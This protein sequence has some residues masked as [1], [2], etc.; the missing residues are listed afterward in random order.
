[1]NIYKSLTTPEQQKI[2]DAR[3]AILSSDE[4]LLPIKVTS[5]YRQK[6][7]D[8]ISILGHTEGPLHRAVFPSHERITL[9]AP[10][11]VADFVH[12]RDNMEKLADGTIIRKYHERM[13][14]LP[15][16]ECLS[17][18]QYCFRQDVLSEQ[19]QE[20][21]LLLR[22]RLD[23]L[24]EYLTEHPE[25]QEVILSG[26]DPIM[27]PFRKL[28]EVFDNIM[29]VGSVQ[30][31]RLHTRGLIFNPRV[32]TDDKISLLGEHR[33]RV[34]NHSIH[35][36]ELCDEVKRRIDQLHKHNIRLYNQFP[37]LRKIND[38]V[39]VLVRHLRLL[40][41]QGIRNLSIFIPDAIH[42]SSAFRMSINRLFS[43]IDEF[44]KSTPSWVNSTRFVLDTPYGKVRREDMT[45]Y[46]ET[47]GEAV[48]E[49]NGHKITYPGLPEHMDEPGNLST[50]LWKDSN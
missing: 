10:G 30:A 27:L 34:V 23:G 4:R 18:C 12:D 41:E 43:I 5:F 15:T 16:S 42:Y 37:I 35:P 28:K 49:R 47:T 3:F 50:L 2:L 14:F 38:H 36:Y 1:M 9:K 40:D 45:S 32:F 48:F 7:A 19:R 6:V 11:E 39:E 17:N 44:N 21:S 33:I 29:G 20:E 13:L 8:E 46:N 26:G 24:L 31:I 25:I 22:E